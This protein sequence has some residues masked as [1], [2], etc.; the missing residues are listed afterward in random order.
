MNLIDWKGDLRTALYK[1][2]R[3]TI[4][5]LGEEKPREYAVASESNG[6]EPFPNSICA[7]N[8]QEN[9]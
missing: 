2:S 8:L 4:L 6:A 5:Y 1:R 9:H 7:K 3:K